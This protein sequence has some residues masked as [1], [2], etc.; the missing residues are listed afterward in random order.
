[1]NRT[2]YVLKVVARFYHF[3]ST[4]HGARIPGAIKKLQ[5]LNYYYIVSV[6]WKSCIQNAEFEVPTVAT[7]KST[8]PCSPVVQ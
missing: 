4:A 6:R 8:L 7:I 3:V 1:V 5:S 2:Q